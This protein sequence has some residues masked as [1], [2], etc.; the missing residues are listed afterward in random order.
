[1]KIYFIELMLTFE[2]K[3]FIKNTWKCKNIFHQK[4]VRRTVTKWKRIVKEEH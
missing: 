4:T 3:C 1:M 2:E